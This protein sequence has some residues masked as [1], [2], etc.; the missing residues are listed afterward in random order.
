LPKT[1][2]GILFIRSSFLSSYLLHKKAIPAAEKPSPTAA[3]ANNN[4]KCLNGIGWPE[5]LAKNGKRIW[6]F[7]F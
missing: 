3:G 7:L 1:A 2:G 6:V 4:S 5:G